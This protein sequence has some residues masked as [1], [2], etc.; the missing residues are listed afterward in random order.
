MKNKYVSYNQFIL[1]NQCP[2]RWKLAYIDKIR[3]DTP[4]IY[5]LF[6]NAMHHT[7][8]SYLKAFYANGPGYADQL[9]LNDILKN[10]MSKDYK[11]YLNK[12]VKQGID[13]LKNTKDKPHKITI[14]ERELV[15]EDNL[16]LIAEFQAKKVLENNISKQEMME[17]YYDG[18][19]INEW[20]KKHR[21]DFFNYSTEE[22][23][24]IEY[25]LEKVLKGK[26]LFIGYLDVVIRNKKTGKIRIVDFKTSTEGW[27]YYKKN[28]E[29]T[30]SQLVIYKEFYS[31]KLKLEPE[32]IDVEFIILKRKLKTDIPYPQKRI[33][34]F[35][36]P[37][38]KPTINKVMLKFDAFVKQC[39]DGKG[40]YKKDEF[41]PKIPTKSNCRFC[42][43][44][45]KPEHCDKK[46]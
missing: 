18:V 42:D 4:S 9:D 41:Y 17:F 28:D 21:T 33:L 11:D 20:F 6:G 40:D 15:V 27:K 12:Y 8:Q 2:W 29:N 45:D 26:L 14:D 31:E 36:P 30:T 35:I 13:I 43:F 1:W 46:N 34:K 32:K 37:S 3:E 44:N 23:I 39:F 19:K 38:G 22:L 16:Q 25:K 7:L 5:L 10:K 24:N